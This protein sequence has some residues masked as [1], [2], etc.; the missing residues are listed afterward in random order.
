MCWARPP[1]RRCWTW[2]MP[3]LSSGRTS[4]WTASTPPWTAGSDPRQFARQIVDYLRDLLLVRMGNAGQVDATAEVREKMALQMQKFS[5]PEL[6][7]VIRVFNYAAGEAR[8]AWQPALPLEMAF[9]EAL[10]PSP[11][12]ESAAPS[13]PPAGRAPA[14]PRAPA[15]QPQSPPQEPS[16]KTPSCPGGSGRDRSP[17]SAKAGG[18]LASAPGAG[19]AAEP[20]SV[21]DVE[22][23]HL[24]S[25]A[26]RPF[27]AE[28]RQRCAEDQDGKARKLAAAAQRAAAGFRQ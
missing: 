4:G 23:I 20:V 25:D 17:G 22:F 1:A 6:L 18:G 21:W 5:T 12:V 13:A 24:A 15:P 9:I 10:E 28:L 19:A 16:A 2:S 14:P 11:A 26:R 27:D 8:S 7:R 3:W